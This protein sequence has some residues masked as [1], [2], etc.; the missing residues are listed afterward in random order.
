MADLHGPCVVVAGCFIHYPELFRSD[1]DGSR[2]HQKF[3][4]HPVGETSV[5]RQ[6]LPTPTMYADLFKRR[7][8]DDGFFS[9]GPSLNHPLDK[10][11]PTFKEINTSKGRYEYFAKNPELE[12]IASPLT[13]SLQRCDD[14]WNEARELRAMGKRVP[15]GQETEEAALRNEGKKPLKNKDGSERFANAAPTSRLPRCSFL[16]IF[17]IFMR[18]TSAPAYRAISGNEV[19]AHAITGYR[20]NAQSTKEFREL[21]M[22]GTGLLGLPFEKIAKDEV[23]ANDGGPSIFQAFVGANGKATLLAK[24]E[25]EQVYPLRWEVVKVRTI[26]NAIV[27]GS[28]GRVD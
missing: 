4:Q 27:I 3:Y 13:A 14:A 25:E 23:W 12:K 6:F 28:L 16:V 1:V 9:V 15:F 7:V 5:S 24:G 2:L 21:I 17:L 11:D 19:V 18:R 8:L 26:A 22:N 20:Y 10:P